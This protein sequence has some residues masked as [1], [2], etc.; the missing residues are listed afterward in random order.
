[1][2]YDEKVD[3]LEP[4]EVDHVLEAAAEH[5][6][7]KELTVRALLET[8]MRASELAHIKPGWFLD[9]REPRAIQVP[10][11]EPCNCTQCMDQAER[12]L[13][14]WCRNGPSEEEVTRDPELDES[15]LRPDVGSPEYERMLEE[16]RDEKWHPKS[17]AGERKIPVT[18][19]RLYEELRE[20]VEEHDGFSAGRGGIWYRVRKVND[21]LDLP[22]PVTPHV[23][24]HT[25]G[26]GMARGEMPLERLQRAMGHASVENTQVYLHPTYEDVGA[27]AEAAARKRGW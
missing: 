24:R 6:H 3:A 14:R 10:A 8:G 7:R 1:M 22:K 18:D 13:E 20:H 9:D 17:E 16:R 2:M 25:Y 23:L 5:S 19:D 11:H 12:N 4:H 21:D 27:A 15:D 26:T